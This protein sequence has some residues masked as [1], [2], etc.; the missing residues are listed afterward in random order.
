[1]RKGWRRG[2]GVVVAVVLILAS[3]AASAAGLQHRFDVLSTRVRV[4][5][6]SRATVTRCRAD[7]RGFVV[8][9][10]GISAT[11]LR[12]VFRTWQPDPLLASVQVAGDSS[13]A[14]ATLVLGLG[15]SVPGATVRAVV[16]RQTL[17]IVAKLTAPATSDYYTDAGVYLA[18]HGRRQQALAQFRKAIALE[19]NNARA[20]LEAAKVR[21]DLGERSL[22]IFNAKKAWQNERTRD[23]ALALLARLDPANW[24][25]KARGAKPKR[26]SRSRVESQ[27]S[28]RVAQATVP[29]AAAVVEN[30]KPGT[31]ST[32]AVP[33]AATTEKVQAADKPVRGSALGSNATL[34][35]PSSEILTAARTK[36]A[37]IVEPFSTPSNAWAFLLALGVAALFTAPLT[38]FLVRASRK[39]EKTVSGPFVRVPANTPPFDDFQRLLVE[40]SGALDTEPGRDRG[41]EDQSEA[42]V[43]SV[44]KV[45]EGIQRQFP[46]A[47]TTE[48]QAQ[49][50]RNGVLL[51]PDVG[52]PQR[53]VRVELESVLALADRGLPAEE[54]ARRVGVGREEVRLV[55]AMSRS[56][57]R[58]P[59]WTGAGEASLTLTFAE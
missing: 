2:A 59:V 51:S 25:R 4:D 56:R 55:L 9:V 39:T 26:V 41:E 54:I 19:P 1:M 28:D 18:K 40:R 45:V 22:A 15:A 31:V 21:A 6:G 23:E 10:A 50:E 44:L 27:P 17:E 33:K 5:L 8:S 16:R 53:D 42:E 7:G 12:Q 35:E 30:R 37:D 11:R 58:R 13:S 29:S 14:E 34:A 49:T 38:W 36:D 47:S 48:E 43:E 57:S 46:E 32:S 3:D 24:S 52:R 20:Y